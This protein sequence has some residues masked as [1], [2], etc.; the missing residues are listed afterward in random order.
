MEIH[1]FMPKYP[2]IEHT[3]EDIDPYWDEEFNKSIYLKKEFNELRLDAEEIIP[4]G[5]GSLFRHQE[6]MTRLVSVHTPY[7]NMLLVHQ[8][9]SGKSCAVIGTTE[10]ILSQ[11]GP[12]KS[13]MVFA[14][15]KN[16][17]DNFTR[18]IVFK[19]TD[20]RYIPEN[21][22]K[23]TQL[24]R[25]IRINKSV[26]SNYSLNTFEVFAKEL[27]TLT[28]PAIKER[29]SHRVIIIDE[30]HNLRIQDNANRKLN[31]YH[32]FWRL[33]HVV[34]GCKTLLLSGTP[35]RD[36]PEEIASIM[37]LI[38]PIDKQFAYRG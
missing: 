28:D 36:G 17:L 9:G 33:L 10:K 38:L 25:T 15:G 19:C 24:E 32:Q 23:L 26:S 37:N 13:A 2:E 20:G 3:F 12:I 27:R 22:E 14:N 35:M 8:M 1:D 31:V 11:K 4:E 16:L 5:P 7:D 18:E 30:V 34:E 29:F 6:L 21:Y